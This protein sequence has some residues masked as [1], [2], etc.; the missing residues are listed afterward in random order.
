MLDFRWFISRVGG[1]GL[2]QLPLFRNE[3]LIVIMISILAQQPFSLCPFQIGYN[4]AMVRQINLYIDPDR[5][6]T[7][8]R[9]LAAKACRVRAIVRIDPDEPAYLDIGRCYDCRLCIPACPFGAISTGLSS[10][11]TQITP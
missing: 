4:N 9:C 11:S 5:C 1:C 8:R 7:C 10:R 2:F 3:R 6:R